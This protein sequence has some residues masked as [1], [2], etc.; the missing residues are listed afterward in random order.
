MWQYV[1]LYFIINLVLGLILY[2]YF[3]P[4]NISALGYFLKMILFG[5]ILI[6]ALLVLVVFVVLAGASYNLG[7]SIEDTIRGWID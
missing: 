7:D 6:I 5:L 1:L 4:K 3:Q 2:L